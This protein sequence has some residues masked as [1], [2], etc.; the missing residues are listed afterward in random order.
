[1]TRQSN[2]GYVSLP[3]TKLA[4]ITIPSE[5]F[6]V[7]ADTIVKVALGDSAINMWSVDSL[8]T[9]PAYRRR[10]FAGALIDAI[11]RQVS[12]PSA[13]NHNPNRIERQADYESRST[14]LFSS[15]PINTIHTASLRLRM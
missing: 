5:E 8:V 6:N 7:E 9:D 1:M 4:F 11:T 14:M 10:G 12:I 3:T 2:V 13:Y 15:N